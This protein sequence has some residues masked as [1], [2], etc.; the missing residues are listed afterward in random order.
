MCIC[1]VKRLP[2]NVKGKLGYSVMRI[3]ENRQ[4]KM[5]LMARLSTLISLMIWQN[6]I[7]T[8]ILGY[9]LGLIDNSYVNEGTRQLVIELCEY[10]VDLV[11][12]ALNSVRNINKYKYK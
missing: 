1:E 2:A 9:C 3:C 4:S 12:L 7:M 11:M 8:R 6:R 5:L 10:G